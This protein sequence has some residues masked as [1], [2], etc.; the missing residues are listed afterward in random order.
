MSGTITEPGD[1]VLLDRDGW[2]WC[3]DSEGNIAVAT[4]PYS[5]AQDCA[6]AVRTFLREVY[7][8]TTDGVPWWDEVL[9][10]TP[11]MALLKSRI[12]A[13]AMTVPGT[14]TAEVFITS[15]AA[16]TV[17]GQLRITDTQGGQASA[18]F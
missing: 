11:P 12:V 10:K 16:R 7:Y 6:S 15:V 13:A 18:S 8:D 2:S 17:S 9:G 5:V 1:T 14:A 3:L 4:P